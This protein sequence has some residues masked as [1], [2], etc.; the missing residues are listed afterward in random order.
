MEYPSRSEMLAHIERVLP[1]MGQKLR[2]MLDKEPFLRQ[3]NVYGEGYSDR[4]IDI[5][6]DAIFRHEYARC[7]ILELTTDQARSVKE[8]AEA[9]GEAPRDILREVV[10]LRRKNLLAL[11]TIKDRTPLYRAAR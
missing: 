7:R 8:I 11:E 1:D 3:G 10:E 4:Q 6:F 9:L 5:C 2:R